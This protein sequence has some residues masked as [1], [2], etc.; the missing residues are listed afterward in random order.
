MQFACGNKP[1]IDLAAIFKPSNGLSA[2]NS[3]MQQIKNKKKVKSLCVQRSECCFSMRA[4]CVA[5]RV[6]SSST[7]SVSVCSTIWRRRNYVG[8]THTHTHKMSG[9]I[10]CEFFFS[11]FCSSF[12][13]WVRKCVRLF[14][15]RVNV[16]LSIRAKAFPSYC[17]I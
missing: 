10:V 12:V 8:H 1:H 14:G 11:S 9:R 5:V 17:I 15:A 2:I 16:N 13:R 6:F 4:V 3:S 7:G